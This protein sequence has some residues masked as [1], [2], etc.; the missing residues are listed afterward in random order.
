M[1]HRE[2][3]LGAVEATAAELEQNGLTTEAAELRT[4]RDSLGRYDALSRKRLNQRAWELK[5]R[6]A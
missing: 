1:H 2:E 3:A 4:A 5:R 6:R